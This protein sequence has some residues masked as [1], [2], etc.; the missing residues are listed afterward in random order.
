MLDVDA[1]TAPEDT[2]M[3]KMVREGGEGTQGERVRGGEIVKGG[4]GGKWKREVNRR[5]C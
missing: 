2:E 3:P 1:G 5:M 4:E